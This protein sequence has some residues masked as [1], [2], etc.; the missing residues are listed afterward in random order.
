MRTQPPDPDPE[1]PAGTRLSD[2]HHDYDCSRCNSRGGPCLEA[3]WL[4]Q[5]LAR[6][7]AAR[8]ADLPAEFELTSETSFRGCGRHCAVRLR[9]SGTAL[10]IACD[11][12]GSAAQTRPRARVT[13]ALRLRRALASA[14]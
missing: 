9:V 8:A 6:S 1:P 2:D 7:L 10:D 14:G 11:P 13:A 5:R 4:A 12:P 3:L